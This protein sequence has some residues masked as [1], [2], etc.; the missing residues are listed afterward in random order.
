M[1]YFS[2]LFSHEL[3]NNVVETD[4]Y[5]RDEITEIQ[6]SPRSICSWWSDDCSQN[7]GVT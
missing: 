1:D 2:I 6:L 4:R 3:L 5:V 7:E